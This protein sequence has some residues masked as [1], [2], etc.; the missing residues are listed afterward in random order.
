MVLVFT[1]AAMTWQVP[2]SLTA[3][4]SLRARAAVATVA[5]AVTLPT[6]GCQGALGPVGMWGTV[7][8]RTLAP[9]P[10]SEEAAAP[11]NSQLQ[12]D[13]RAL[14][15]RWVNPGRSGL[16]SAS[17][18]WDRVLAAVG[19]GKP[20]PKAVEDPKVSA[21]ADAEFEQVE[22][23]FRQGDF[24]NAEIGFARIARRRKNTNWGE[25]ALY[26]LAETQ[27]QRGRYLATTDTL[28]ELAKTYPST[29]YLERLAE[30][31][32]Q[33]AE[34]WLAAAS[35]VA[36]AVQPGGADKDKAPNANAN[37][38]ADA[39][40]DD[41]VRSASTDSSWRD[42]FNGRMPLVDSGGHAV[43]VFEHVRHH[44]PTG[45]LADKAALKIADYYFGLKDY[46][47]ASMYYD[48]L[49]RDHPKS[50][51][52]QRALIAGIDA[53]MRGY[54]GPD[55]DGDGLEKAR[56]Q[57]KQA[58]ALFPEN[59]ELQA[60][61]THRLD[62]INDQEAERAFRLGS[63]YQRVSKAAAAEFYYGKV[64]ARWPESP[65]AEKAKSQMAM[66][67]KMPR[68]ETLPSKIMTRPGSTDPLLNGTPGLGF[69]GL[70]QGGGGGGGGTGMAG[71][72]TP[73]F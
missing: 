15:D 3:C 9:P 13:R 17:G 56:E 49:I 40:R 67:A 23:L 21:A 32:Y 42:K 5:L 47:S 20:G 61:L 57:I 2:R 22:Q 27:F 37:T 26:Y 6:T 36:A 65:W 59:G 70:G 28:E 62:L 10:T 35:P 68:T 41:A 46:E 50:P 4:R 73:N 18:A 33:I 1:R 25:K 30:R 38:N 64:M 45:P 54:Y 71:Q 52:L 34:T 58:L 14:L 51:L 8:D 55:Y 12:D 31:E 16:G 29:K 66:L 60:D 53:K 72:G 44:D 7:K 19:A 11:K 39:P 63:F 48:Q 69:G 24:A 43:R